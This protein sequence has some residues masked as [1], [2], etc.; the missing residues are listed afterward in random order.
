VK[1]HDDAR[2]VFEMFMIKAALPG[3]E[4]TIADMVRD[5]L[6]TAAKLVGPE[7][8]FKTKDELAKGL[9]TFSGFRFVSALSPVVQPM[10]LVVAIDQW[11]NANSAERENLEEEPRMK[12]ARNVAEAIILWV[13]YPT[14]HPPS[15]GACRL[16]SI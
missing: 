15:S 5:P 16:A 4:Y 13:Y 8:P 12:K 11:L 1:P 14:H 3:V 6:Y 9:Y 10:S 7:L 2:N